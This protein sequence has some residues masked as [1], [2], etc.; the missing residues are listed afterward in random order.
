MVPRTAAAKTCSRTLSHGFARLRW[1][2]STAVVH[3]PSSNIQ[4]IS[5]KS[6]FTDFF[7]PPPTTT[8]PPTTSPEIIS[9]QMEQEAKEFARLSEL[10]DPKTFPA[11]HIPPQIQ[12]DLPRPALRALF[13]LHNA[14]ENFVTHDNLDAAIDAAF[15]RSNQATTMMY[16]HRTEW[17]LAELEEEVDKIR[18]SDSVTDDMRHLREL[19]DREERR[20]TDFTTQRTVVY[21]SPMLGPEGK[22][23]VSF[24]SHSKAE[25]RELAVRAALYGVEPV[26]K[27]TRPGLEAVEEHLAVSKAKAKALKKGKK[28]LSKWANNLAMMEGEEE[29]IGRQRPLRRRRSKSRPSP[30]APAES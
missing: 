17:K 4:P 3:Q 30:E 8:N 14:A 11:P 24:W 16:K 13:A 9:R 27:R 22:D 7:Q 5:S 6:S 29:A 15:A 21:S 19:R 12:P 23:Q 1:I 10:H 2:T 20:Q 18:G 28:E 25:S 26:G